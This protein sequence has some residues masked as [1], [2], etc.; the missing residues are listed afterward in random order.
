MSKEIYE[1]VREW[2]KGKWDGTEEY[3][4]LGALPQY[5]REKIKRLCDFAESADKVAMEKIKELEELKKSDE[6]KEQSSID[7]YNEMRKY[8]KELEELKANQMKIKT[9]EGYG[10]DDIL[11]I[12]QG[13][14][15]KE[16]TPEI[17]RN[18]LK[19]YKAGYENGIKA[20]RYYIEQALK[21]IKGE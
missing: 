9:I 20:S 5:M 1:E 2:V 17:L 19:M 7:Y 3:G 11:A 8:K 15:S 18:H 16:I 4:I 12:I 13:L 14:K 21:N 6:S 10:I